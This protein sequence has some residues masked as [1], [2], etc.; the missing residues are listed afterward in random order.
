M[1]AEAPLAI[2]EPKF[3]LPG[4]KSVEITPSGDMFPVEVSG[5]LK[6][7]RMEFR[8]LSGPLKGPHV[9]RPTRRILFG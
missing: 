4:Q 7:T 2:L 6:P 9:S 1:P 3:H 5:E 8:H